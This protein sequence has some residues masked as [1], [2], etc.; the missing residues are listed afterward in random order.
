MATTTPNFGWAVPTSTDLV[1]DGAVAIETLGDSID[2]SL[3]DLKGGTTG[4]V[5][6]KASGTDMDFSWTTPAGSTSFP[7]FS[8][9][10]STGAGAQTFATGTFT[11]I[12]F[13][14]E[15]WDTANNF[16]SSTFTPTVA[17]Y[18]SINAA[19]IHEQ[20][21]NGDWQFSVYK[22]G[23]RHKRITTVTTTAATATL[24]GG[25][26]L[27]YCN[28]TTD[29]IEIYARGD[30]GGTVTIYAAEDQTYFQGIG[31]RS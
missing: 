17:G 28:G 9:Y 2:A 25:Q 3:V 31:I 14:T 18:Y 8:A 7:T 4:Q 15:S 20:V 11:K 21:S 30:T 22:N 24:H 13:D 27:V 5:L 6:A 19:L 10:K 26:C 1:K 23:V 29:Y 12:T 16:A